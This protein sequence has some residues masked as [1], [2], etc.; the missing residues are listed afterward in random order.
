MIRLG[1]A[2]V[3]AY[4]KLRTHRVRTGIAIAVAGLLFGLIAAVIIVA[5]GVFDSVD[6]FSDEGLNNRT[7]LSVSHMPQDN[8]FNEYDHRDD[9][10]FIAEVEKA[11]NALVQ[12]K[13]AA[14]KKYSVMYDAP[15]QDPSPIGI[16]PSTK[17]KTI[18][19]SS[20][21]SVAVQQIGA[22]RRAQV[23][24]PFD[25]NAYIKPYSTAKVLGLNQNLQPS[26]GMLTYMKDGKEIL[27]QNGGSR[28]QS[29]GT[30]N[31]P[32]TLN[33]LEASLT[34]PFISVKTFDSSKGEIPAII[35]YSTAEKIL[36]YK[37]LSSSAA[38]D[39]KLQRLKEVRLRIHEA[40]VSYC[41]R[42]QASQLLLTQALTQKADIARNVSNKEYTK[43]HLTYSVPS[44]SDCGAVTI[45]A[46]SR[47]ANEKKQDAN[48]VLYDKEVGEYIG[49]PMQMKVI[50]RGIGVSNDPL[51]MSDGSVSSLIQGFLGS[52]LGYNSLTIPADM[53]QEVPVQYRPDAIFANKIDL[54]TAAAYYLPENYLVEFGDKEQARALMEK[55][56]ATIGGTV[57]G[58]MY[59]SPFG[60]GVLVV[61]E[62]RRMFE[63]VL[64]WVF[65]IVG[66]VA[67]IILGSMIGRT[68]AEGRRESAIFRAI[69]AKRSDIGTI[70]GM[71]TL[72]LC[73][74]AVIFAVILAVVLAG[75]VELMF[76]HDATLGA[77]L[78]YAASD[79]TREFHLFSLSSP[80]LLAIA[81]V[82]IA[83]G[84]IASI[85]PILLGARRS[86]IK[87]MRDDT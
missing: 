64:V 50:I 36:G 2:A 73:L 46:D 4:T 30:N 19:D 31:D 1:D 63:G 62:L 65:L 26:D 21:G 60:S 17:Q 80:Y 56:G 14:A 71:Y 58:D 75:V 55:T 86:P 70:Y 42:N 24:T 25:I 82:I 81:G 79:T 67:I 20:F 45:S 68:V 76:W 43:P 59:V 27:N 15:T 51:T 41:Y 8:G 39:E 3:L 7:V 12:K 74:R 83:A 77:R 5:Q 32:P 18:N 53:L 84:L 78:A 66:T 44:D 13:Q 72:L 47:T 11:H 54:T 6:R 34:K 49:E 23:Y 57:T 16:D 40:T 48:Q 29:F 33:I 87:D 9:P 61:D 85:I 69:G 28:Q 22:A 10:E 38:T 35:P 37:P 52:W